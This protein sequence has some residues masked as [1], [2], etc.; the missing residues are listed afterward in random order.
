ML[1]GCVPWP[2]AIAQSYRDRGYWRGATLGTVLRSAAATFGDRTVL[3]HGRRRVSYTALDAWA[4]RLATGF[5]RCGIKADERVVVQLPNVP[6][7]VAV[8]F[9]LFRLGAK[10][11]FALLAHRGTEIRHLCERSG[12]SGYVVPEAHRGFDHLALAKQI[13]DEVQSL[14]SVFVLGE[15]SEDAISLSELSRLNEAQ[16][17]LPEHDPTDVA[18]F[19]LSGGTTALPKIIPRTHDDYAYQ[20]LRAAQVCELSTKDV[21]LAALPIGFT[22]AWGCPGVLGTLQTGGTVVLADSPNPGACFPLI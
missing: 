4:D 2:S 19:L 1:E 8:A 13:R 3:I 21:Y 20:S 10:P 5:A 11:V 15:P 17:E 7:F 9:A 18:F 6:E 12:A 14:R 22:F 16:P